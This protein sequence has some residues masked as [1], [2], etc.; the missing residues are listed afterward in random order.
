MKYLIADIVTMKLRLASD[1]LLFSYICIYIEKL[2]SWSFPL[3]LFMQ[4]SL[5]VDPLLRHDIP[6]HDME[7][8]SFLSSIN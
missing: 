1:W 3:M 4:N 2:D 8:V 5:D 6:R 7:K